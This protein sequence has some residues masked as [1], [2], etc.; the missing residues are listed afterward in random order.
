MYFALVA[1]VHTPSDIVQKVYSEFRSIGE[2]PQFRER[3][4]IEQG[5]VPV[6][7]TPKDFASYLST[8]RAEAKRRFEESGMEQR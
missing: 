1:P 7:D 3:R 4:L 2:D 8:N 6:F 5:L